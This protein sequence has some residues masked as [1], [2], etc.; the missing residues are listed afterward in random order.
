MIR[1]SWHAELSQGGS[2]DRRPM[3][4]QEPSRGDFVEVDFSRQKRQR[5][6]L[7]AAAAGG[8]VDEACALA[9]SGDLDEKV[10]EALAR[11]PESKVAY[12]LANNVRANLGRKA[13]RV[14]ME[15]GRED[16]RLAQALLRR[17]DLHLCHFRLFLQASE[18]ERAHLIAVARLSHLDTTRGA[19]AYPE[20]NAEK[21][22]R[23]E[24]AALDGDRAAFEQAFAE[25]LSCGLVMARR[26]ARD[27]GG[28]ALA[29]ALAALG[30]D[31]ERAAQIFFSR[32]PELASDQKIR[33]LMRIV[34]S[35][36]RLTAARLV[37]LIVGYPDADCG[38]KTAPP[39]AA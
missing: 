23:L 20:P 34:S 33:A 15:R 2:L 21:V 31:Y 13:L 36:P 19:E 29:L 25:A 16:A 35:V 26:I 4:R 3:A 9:E 28:E 22:A 10:V 17:E 7:T 39:D 12:A 18:E 38:P 14:L 1:A 24:Q 5:E 8:P 32:L 6:A 11:R 37:R 30:L 27:K